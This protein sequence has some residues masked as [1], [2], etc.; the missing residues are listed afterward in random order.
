MFIKFSMI[1][2]LH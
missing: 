2:R 1:I